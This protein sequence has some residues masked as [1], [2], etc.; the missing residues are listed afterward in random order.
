MRGK[1]GYTLAGLGATY[2]A[3]QLGR[4]T[5]FTGTQNR[6]AGRRQNRQRQPYFPPRAQRPRGRGRSRPRRPQR[7][8]VRQKKRLHQSAT[9]SCDGSFLCFNHGF[10]ML[11]FTAEVCINDT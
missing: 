2:A 7:T 6:I 1:V 5:G 4:W 3:T 10:K 11:L 9:L 8:A